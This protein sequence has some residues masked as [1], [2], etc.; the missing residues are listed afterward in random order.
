MCLPEL[1]AQEP[2]VALHCSKEAPCL[3]QKMRLLPLLHPADA[4]A[5][6]QDP[7]FVLTDPSKRL[8]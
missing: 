2:L 1:L 3:R 8:L 7:G 4:P 6:F 5:L